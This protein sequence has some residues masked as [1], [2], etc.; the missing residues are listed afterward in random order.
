GKTTLIENLIR[1]FAARNLSVSTV[2]LTHHDIE[3]DPPGKDSRRHREAGAREVA[4]VGP[5]RTQIL[6]EEVPDLPALLQRL[7]PV[8]LILVEGFLDADMP[9]IEIFRSELGE[10]LRALH[11][12]DLVAIAS[13]G[14]VDTTLPLLPLN[15]AAAIADFILDV[16]RR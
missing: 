10:T 12:S 16:L 8:D 14:P 3:P 11:R 7:A 6:S 13:D 9:K 5:K 15:D 1:I 2:K 4:L